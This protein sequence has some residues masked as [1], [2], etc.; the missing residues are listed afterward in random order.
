[1]DNAENTVS[2]LENTD[3]SAIENSLKSDILSVDDNFSG[4]FQDPILIGED[5]TEEVLNQVLVLDNRN[6]FNYSD[7]FDEIEL[8]QTGDNISNGFEL[9]FP[10]LLA[11]DVAIKNNFESTVTVQGVV[12]GGSEKGILL[13]QEVKERKNVRKV[14]VLEINNPR[15]SEQTWLIIHGWNDAPGGR[16]IDIAREISKTKPGDRVLLLDWR[17]A[18]YNKSRTLGIKYDVGKGNFR[19][20]TWISPIAEFAVK[21]LKDFYGID[22]RKASQSLNLIGHSLGSLVNSEMGRI[23]RDGLILDNRRILSGNKQGVRTITALEPPSAR[24][25]DRNPFASNPK[26][27]I[28]DLDGRV[29]GIQAPENYADVS[30]FS[31]TFVGEKSIAGNPGLAVTADEA[32]QMD[33]GTKSEILTDFGKEHHRVVKTFVNIINQPGLIGDLLGIRAYESIDRLPIKEFDNLRIRQEYNG[34]YKGVIEVNKENQAVLL[35]GKSNNG[36]KDDIVIGSLGKQKINGADFLGLDGDSRYTGK[37]K[38][39]FFGESGNDII[40]GNKHDDI[41]YGGQGK[42]KLD[43]GQGKDTF[44]FKSGDGGSGKDQADIIEDFKPGIDKI[45]LINLDFSQLRFKE[46][47]RRNGLFSRTTDTAIIVNSEFL[48]L[49]ENMKIEEIKKRENFISIDEGKLRIR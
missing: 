41:L 5:F 25:R 6:G 31:R 11:R 43:G 27:D 1:M 13:N 20:A 12:T 10:S 16:F 39:I 7:N 34:A 45:G 46:F 18:A 3:V 49:L 24:N 32:F 17:E 22:A 37:G 47:R 26:K 36:E 44:V 29:A 30:V 14:G 33:F 4:S 48:V 19:A 21:A 38:D 8:E 40:V 23:Y 9:E 2:N 42:D 28:Y 35:I 15:N